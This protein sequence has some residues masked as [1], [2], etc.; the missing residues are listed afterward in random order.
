MKKIL[1]IL[2]CLFFIGTGFSNANIIIE[3]T[4]EQQTCF[5][6][7]GDFADSQEGLSHEESF[8]YFAVCYDTICK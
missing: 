4:V 7:C 5:D 8:E 3:E 1:L 6:L 2:P